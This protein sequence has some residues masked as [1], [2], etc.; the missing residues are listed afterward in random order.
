MGTSSIYQGPKDKNPLLPD[1][2]IKEQE[3]IAEPVRWKDAKTSMSQYITGNSSNR[4][5]VVRNHVKAT[6]GA[7]AASKQ[8]VAGRNSTINLGRFLGGIRENGLI[9]TLR[10]FKIEHEGKTIETLLSEI[11]NVISPAASTKED[12]IARNAT[13]E[14]MSQVYEFIQENNMDFSSLETMDTIMV[15]QI[16]NSYVS[17]YLF[18]RMLNDLQSSFEKY[19]TSS[20]QALEKEIEFKEYI[21]S[22]VEVKLQ[23]IGF[24]TMDYANADISRV[25]EEL[26]TDCYEVLE[27]CL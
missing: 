10:D 6:G 17:I 3:Y 7:R 23:S 27:G 20:G 14:V 8:A 26:Y 5:R 9:K 16:M 25:I 1:D 19:A 18:E 11:V 15:D 2:F 21:Q 12:I 4:G 13:I 22:S 24:S